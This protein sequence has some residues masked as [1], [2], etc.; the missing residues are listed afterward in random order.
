MQNTPTID[1]REE[2]HE[3]GNNNNSHPR[4]RKGGEGK[5]GDIEHTRLTRSHAR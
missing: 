2:P 4:S 3:R 1:D 5:E